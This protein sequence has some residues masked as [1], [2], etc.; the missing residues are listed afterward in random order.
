MNLIVI[1]AEF[2]ECAALFLGDKVNVG[3][4]LV[5]FHQFQIFPNPFSSFPDLFRVPPP[6]YF[7]WFFRLPI[8]YVARG[9]KRSKLFGEILGQFHHDRCKIR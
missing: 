9:E 8:K 4:I 6:Q 3:E 7:T 1:V 5:K 2:V